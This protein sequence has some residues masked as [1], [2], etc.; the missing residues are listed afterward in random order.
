ML[1]AVCIYARKEKFC[2][3]VTQEQ[4]GRDV[5]AGEGHRKEI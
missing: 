1:C 2:N 5:H 3:F 4:N